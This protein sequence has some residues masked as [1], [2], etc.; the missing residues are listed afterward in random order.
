[1]RE[2][3]CKRYRKTL[4][5]HL[6]NQFDRSS[7]KSLSARKRRSSK[8]MMTSTLLFDDNSVD[9]FFLS[10]DLRTL[11]NLHRI[12]VGLIIFVVA[13][14]SWLLFKF[15]FCC[16]VST[17]RSESTQKLVAAS[18]SNRLQYF[19]IAPRLSSWKA[20]HYTRAV[21]HSLSC[22]RERNVR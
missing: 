20:S 22:A 2:N 3:G 19:V 21:V 12:L 15:V 17:C 6:S 1:M 9:T 4:N 7:S 16:K 8:L 13:S 18:F 10:R 14:M 5:G 11:Q